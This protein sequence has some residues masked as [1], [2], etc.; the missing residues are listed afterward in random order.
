M[1]LLV[2]FL[3][4]LLPIVTPFVLLVVA[5]W[6][7]ARAMPVTY[8]VTVVV[9]MLIWQVSFVQVAASTVQGFIVTLEILYIVFG[10]ILLLKIM[11]ESGAFNTIREGLL[12]ISRDRRVQAI[13]IAWLFGSFIES[14]SGFGST[15]VICVPILIAIGFPALAAII[16]ALIIQVPASTFGAVGTPILIGLESGLEGLERVQQE[17]TDLEIS[18]TDYLLRIT[19]ETGLLHGLVSIFVPLFLVIVLTTYFGKQRTWKDG[20]SIA[21]FALFAGAAFAIPYSLT[22]VF[23]GPAFPSLLGSLV[24][25]A[26]VITVARRGWLMPENAWDFPPRSEWLDTW[27]GATT[28]HLSDVQAPVPPIKAWMPYG[29]LGVLLILSRLKTLPFHQWLQAFEISF[30]NI[31]GTDVSASVQPLFLP[32]TIFIVVIIITCFLHQLKFNQIRRAVR[33]TFQKTVATALAIGASV[34]LAKV[35]INSGV[36]AS[37]LPSIPITLADGV[38]SLLGQVW[39]FF[40]PM[41]GAIGTFVSGSATVSN[42]M[43]ASFQFGVAEQAGFAVTTILSLQ[44]IG[45]SIGN[46]IAVA[47]IVP[48]ITIAGA[49]GREG[50]VLGRLIPLAIGYLGVVGGIGLI[51]VLA[52]G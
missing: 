9:A 37:G 6:P 18:L 50:L 52:L 14:A 30:S 16:T 28:L 1:N 48:A 35:F 5:N 39:P 36:N 19:A 46:M 7:A 4:A 47:N 26:V 12:G 49:L 44:S 31:F 8:L 10:A 32:A 41:I 11:Q 42:I 20:L 3:F 22:A 40:A 25:L 34:P 13:I 15:P 23:L 24:A 51:V 21:W 2:Y 33:G 29:L 27:G 43:F 38:S 17:V 45:S